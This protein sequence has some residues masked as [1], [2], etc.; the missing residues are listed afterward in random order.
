MRRGVHVHGKVRMEGY[1]KCSFPPILEIH[2]QLVISL[3]WGPVEHFAQEEGIA[4]GRT[5]LPLSWWDFLLV[6]N[7]SDYG[8][9]AYIYHLNFSAKV[10]SERR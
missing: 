2:S 4:Q 9:A 3:P 10:R 1:L 7:A 6:F 8:L 5:L